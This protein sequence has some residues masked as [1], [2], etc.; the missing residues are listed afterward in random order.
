MTRLDPLTRPKECA[1]MYPGSNAEN[2]SHHTLGSEWRRAG[3]RIS[4]GSLLAEGGDNLGYPA[5]LCRA[6]FQ[7]PFP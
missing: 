1:Q 7:L 3:V 2:T 5:K 6:E 4:V